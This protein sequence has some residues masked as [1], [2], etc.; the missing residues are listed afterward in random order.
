MTTVGFGDIRPIS[1]LE[2]GYVAG[3]T[4]LSSLCFA[5]TVNTIGSVF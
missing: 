5:Y 4:L 3:M 1:T 2:K